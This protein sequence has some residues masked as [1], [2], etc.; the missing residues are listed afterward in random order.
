MITFLVRMGN[1]GSRI[2]EEVTKGHGEEK[3]KVLWEENTQQKDV[4]VKT[5]DKM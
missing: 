4:M 3:G 5:N 1:F 2:Q